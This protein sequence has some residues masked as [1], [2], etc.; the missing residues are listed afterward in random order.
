MP[1]L[2]QIPLSRAGLTI[3]PVV[4]WEGAPPP[5]L[6]PDQLPNFYYAVSTFERTFGNHKFRGC[7][8]TTTKTKKN[9]VN[10]LREEKCILGKNPGY[11]YEKSAPPYVGMPPGMVNPAL[12]Q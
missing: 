2:I 3:V 5:G 8:I 1:R 10:F 7:N 11:A 4:P 12:L 9:V 6:P